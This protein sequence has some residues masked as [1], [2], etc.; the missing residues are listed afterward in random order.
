MSRWPY[1]VP[2]IFVVLM[3]GIVV[4]KADCGGAAKER[5]SPPAP[6]TEPTTA[7]D[8]EQCAT[9]RDRL[10]AELRSVRDELEDEQRTRRSAE[11]DRDIAEDRARDCRR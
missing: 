9:E 5:E 6:R 4:N 7:A 1:L 2:V 10:E 3:V 11:L 8:L